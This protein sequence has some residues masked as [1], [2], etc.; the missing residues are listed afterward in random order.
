VQLNYDRLKKD[1]D[2]TRVDDKAYFA[3]GRMTTVS[4]IDEIDNFDHWKVSMMRQRS[5]SVMTPS[6][7]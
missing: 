5:V 2:V 7:V 6:G 1:C 3:I 4:R